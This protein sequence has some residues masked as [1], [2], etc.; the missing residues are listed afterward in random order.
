[1]VVSSIPG[2]RVVELQPKASCSHPHTS[3]GHSGL[4]VP[5]RLQCERLQPVVSITTA[6]AIVQPLARAAHPYCQCLGRQPTTL[7]G[8]VKWVSAFGLSNNNKW[9]WFRHKQRKSRGQRQNLPRERPV[10]WPGILCRLDVIQHIISSRNQPLLARQFLTLRA[11]IPLS[12][13]LWYFVI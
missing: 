10:A 5:C 11:W 1:M 4:V 2:C 12:I 9:R 8:M 3:A 13:T 6:T 7:C